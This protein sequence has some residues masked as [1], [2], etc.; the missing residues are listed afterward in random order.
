MIAKIQSETSIDIEAQPS[1]LRVDTEAHL[2]A[3]C[4]R[5]S[6]CF[7]DK[8]KPM[9]MPMQ[10]FE[11]I[12]NASD[13]AIPKWKY[14]LSLCFVV[15]HVV[16]LGFMV[17]T[18]LVPPTNDD[19]AAFGKA[20]SLYLTAT[21]G[22]LVLFET[23]QHWMRGTY[24]PMTSADSFAVVRFNKE[25]STDPKEIV[26]GTIAAMTCMST[27][28]VACSCFNYQIALLALETLRGEH[29]FSDAEI[30][31][32]RGR[33]IMQA[34][35]MLLQ[36]KRYALAYIFLVVGIVLMAALGILTLGHGWILLGILCFEGFNQDTSILCIRCASVHRVIAF[37]YRNLC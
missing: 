23:I 36:I 14:C 35:L 29:S 5:C 21:C 37:F 3:T 25:V 10:S 17:F 31:N 7:A 32:I 4:E 6:T 15:L 28:F 33:A 12:S 20:T 26:F 11:C 1:E 34:V 22:P 13:E 18:G 24:F 19:R 27:F 16:S 30:W 9:L 8:E 2:H